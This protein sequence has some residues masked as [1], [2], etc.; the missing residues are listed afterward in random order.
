MTRLLAVGAI[1]GFLGVMAGCGGSHN[2]ARTTCVGSGNGCTRSLQAAIDAA[3]DGDTIKV[4]RGE[5]AGGI[6]IAKSVRIMGAGA[7]R[8]IVRGG[9]P[10]MTVAR[11]SGGAST[12]SIVGLTITGGVTRTDPARTCG[13]DVPSCGP[14]YLRATALG[15][16]IEIAPRA[17]VT[18]RDSVVA[19]NRATPTVTVPS[20]SAD[21]PS[22]PCAFA[23]GGG[24]GI[25]NWGRLTLQDTAV[26]DNQAGGGVTAQADGGGVLNEAGSRLTLESSTVEGN[27]VVVRKPNARFAAGGGIF[28]GEGGTLS[29]HRSTVGRNRADLTAAMPA[30][31]DVNAQSAGILLAAGSRATIRDS[32]ISSNAVT[33]TNSDGAGTFC[34][35]GLGVDDNSSVVLSGSTISHNR[36]SA[37]ARATPREPGAFLACAGALDLFPDTVRITKTRIVGNSVRAR[38]SSGTALAVAGA[39]SAVAANGTRIADSLISRNRASAVSARGS[40]MVYAGGLHNGHVTRLRRVTVSRNV[41]SAHGR[42]TLTRGGGIYNGLVPGLDFPVKLDIAHSVVAHNRPDQCYGC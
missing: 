16:G 40:A 23:Q 24:G 36:V 27:R 28:L 10:V 1:G 39:I 18:I 21:C 12:V 35:G 4:G 20:V 31:V 8:S 34:R 29:M 13:A 17:T 22:G 30:S 15:G 19:R 7:G 26:R 42:K 32:A 3:H 6:T 38:T 25:D 2:A 37:T 33:G 5:F 14:G 41:A 11:G 9:G